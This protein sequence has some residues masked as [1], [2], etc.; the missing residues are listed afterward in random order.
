MHEIL[1]KI[2][3]RILETATGALTQ[4]NQHAVYYDPG[5]DHWGYIAILNAALAGELFMKAVIAK[6]HPL[7]IFRD[8]FHLDDP[9][10]QDMDFKQ[11]I[12]RGKTYNFEHLPKLLWV[13]TGERLPDMVS[14]EKIRKTR[15]AIQHFCAPE[16]INF[17]RLSLEFIYNNIDPLIHKNFGL[18]AI[19][20]HEDMGVNYDYVVDCLIENELFFSIPDNFR[21]TEIDIHEKLS[22]TKAEYRTEIVRRFSAFDFDHYRRSI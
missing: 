10:N 4:A 5:M 19:E 21:I 11:I 2:P 22:Q 7:L 9:G 1:R 13:A 16:D 17:K 3:D 12:E 15:N 14:F 6:E 8:F 18:C 20:F